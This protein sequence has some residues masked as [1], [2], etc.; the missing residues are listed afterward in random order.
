MTLYAMSQ[1]TATDG[2]LASMPSCW[3]T[4]TSLDRVDIV[5]PPERT[6]S[7]RCGCLA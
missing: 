4:R 6:I 1:V 7:G 2:R 3:A 5:P